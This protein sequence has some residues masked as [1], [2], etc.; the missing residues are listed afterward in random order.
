MENNSHIKPMFLVAMGAI[1]FSLNDLVFK[2]LTKLNVFWWD[3][4]VFGVP[5]EIIIIVFSAG[6]IHKYDKR[7]W[8][9]E[10]LPKRPLYPVLRGLLAVIAI[11]LVFL[12]LKNL[13]L[14][15]TSM[16]LQTA[17]LCMAFIAFFSINERPDTKVLLSIFIGMIGVIFIIN[18]KIEGINLYL[19]LPLIVALLNA[20]MNYILTKRSEDA[21]PLS[22]AL[23]LFLT[24]GIAG[25]LIWIYMGTF[26]PNL[27]Q[28]SLIVVAAFL[29]ALAFI[30]VSYGFSLAA[31]NFARTGVMNYIQL[32]CSI[33]LGMIFFT[34]SP[35][36]NAYFGSIL[37]IFS[38]CFVILKKDFKK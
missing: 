19:I 1:I 31:G 21:T 13:P 38:G 14:S 11:A 15:I 27:V 26:F 37:I 16:L 5:I 8:Y 30:C 6:Y 22:F 28:F 20:L 35:T 17:P 24:N 10:L 25:L 12:S 7:K 2:Y 3:F 18:P 9:K 33:I 36:L 29:G 34:E 23:C 4:L 32:P